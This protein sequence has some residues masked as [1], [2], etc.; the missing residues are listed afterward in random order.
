MSEAMAQIGLSW[1]PKLPSLPSTSCGGSS[2]KDPA[3]S[4]STVRASLW[5]PASELVDGLFVPPRDP[6]KVNKLAK[7]SVKDTSGKGW[8]DMPAP[9]IT[10]ELKKDLE[11]LQL[12][13]VIDPKRHFKRSGK[14]K[15]LPKYF[16]V[17]TIVE[18]ASEF[19]SSRLT[20]KERKTTLVDEILSD[21]S[22]KSYRARKVREIQESRTPGG[23]Q[24][25]KNR[26][27]QTLKRAKDR[28]K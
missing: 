24:K 6:K 26:G 27:K 2:K 25:W 11:I 7:K 8:F 12:R 19:Y 4:P 21:P 17:G 28:R 3:P 16:Q 9:T 13:H 1:A 22:L 23:N 10:P 5:K 20:K 18:P 14:S 15:A